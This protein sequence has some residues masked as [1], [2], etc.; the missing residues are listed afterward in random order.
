MADSEAPLP[1]IQTYQCAA[2]RLGA[3]P[4]SSSSFPLFLLFPCLHPPFIL[5]LLLSKWGHFPSASSWSNYS[6]LSPGFLQKLHTVSLALHSPPGREARGVLFPPGRFFLNF[7]IA[8][9]IPPS[10]LPSEPPS[11]R[12]PSWPPSQLLLPLGPLSCSL[13]PPPAFPPTLH[14]IEILLVYLV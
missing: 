1:R 13:T 7:C 2:L 10:D 4:S 14:A 6:P 5:L 8:P 11:L 3:F 12:G 9:V